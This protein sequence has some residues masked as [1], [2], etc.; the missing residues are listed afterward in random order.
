MD[1]HRPM[2]VVT[3]TLDAEVLSVLARADVE[4]TGREIQRLAGHGSHQGIRNAADR[5]T[6]EGILE[7]RPAG[8]ANLYR[9][10]RDHVA[11]QWIEKLAT[12]PD[13]IID[14]LREAITGWTHPPVLAML[15]GSAA[16]G[17]ATST[18]DLD[19]LIVRSRGCEADDPTWSRQLGDLQALAA[20]SSG[21]DAR[22]LEYGED[23]LTSSDSEA[24]LGDALRDGIEL[25]GSRRVLQ[26]RVADASS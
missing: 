22:V 4:L 24:V 10:N 11:A 25:Y 13:Q 5:L 7:R 9:L 20:A 26:R 12:L 8:N 14:R 19:L 23:E 2:Q 18:S 1:F 17:Q 3:P 16:T 15:F 21:N 6:R